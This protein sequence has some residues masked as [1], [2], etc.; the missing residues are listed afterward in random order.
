MLHGLSAEHRYRRRERRGNG[1]TER[2]FVSL[3]VAEVRINSERL[4]LCSRIADDDGPG[5]RRASE[6]PRNDVEPII[7]KEPKHHD[8]VVETVE[9]RIDD[10]AR[11]SRDRSL[12]GQETIPRIEPEREQQQWTAEAEAPHPDSHGR[13]D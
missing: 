1:E 10:F 9:R 7:V 8:D 13:R 5:E 11:V 3:K 2:P 4:P 6:E 12:A